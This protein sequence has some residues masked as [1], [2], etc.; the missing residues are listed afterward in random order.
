MFV[1]VQLQAVAR[2][3]STPNRGRT[4][5]KLRRCRRTHGD[6]HWG[7]SHLLQHFAKRGEVEVERHELVLAATAIVVVGG[8]VRVGNGD[9]AL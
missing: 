9:L 7:V 2:N 6:Q 8:R 3:S 4:N 5:G 1:A